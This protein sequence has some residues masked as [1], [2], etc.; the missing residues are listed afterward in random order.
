MG[1]NLYKNWLLVSKII[2]GIWIA[3][4]KQWKVQ[5]VEIQWAAFVQKT[6]SFI[7][8][9]YQTLLSTTVKIH[10]VPYAIFETIFHD[11]TCLYFF[12]SNITSFWWKYPIK[13]HIFRFSIAR[14]KIHQIIYIIFQIK[15]G[16]FFNV[17]ITLQCHE[18]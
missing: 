2:W 10:Q 12:S 13:V 6:Y 8:R 17:W 4:H 9:V 1:Q 15:S 7:Q 16:F 11:T 14:V 18:R 5:Q 3:S